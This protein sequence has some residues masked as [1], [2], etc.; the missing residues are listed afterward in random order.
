MVSI[1][2]KGL[3]SG[4]LLLWWP[5]ISVATTPNTVAMSSNSEPVHGAGAQPQTN[6][7][8]SK[9]V[10]YQLMVRLF[11]N[12]NQTNA[13]WGSRQQNGV[14]KLSDINDAALAS[15]KALGVSHIW[16]TGLLHHAT[17]S[18][19]QVYGIS[20]DDPEVVKGRAGSPY[21]I[22]DYYSIHPDL[23]DNPHER[24]AEFQALLARVHQHGLKVIIDLVPNHVARGYQS[25]GKP[26]GVVDFGQQDDT[27]LAYGRDNSFYYVPNVPFQLPQWPAGFHPLGG[28][29]DPRID[30]RFHEFPAKWTG[31][32]ARQPQPAFQDWYETVKV[33]FGV[34]PDGTQDFVRLPEHYRQKDVASHYAFWQQQSVPATWQKFQQIT[35]FWLEQGV[36]GFRYDMAE[37]VPVAFWS[38]LNSH[39]KHLAPQALLLAEIYTPSVY[40]DFLELGKMDYL[41]DKVGLYDTLKG[42]IQGR[43]PVADI[44]SNQQQLHDIRHHMLHFLE[45]HDEQRLASPEFAGDPVRAL[46]ALVLSATLDSAPMMIYFGQEVGEPAAED[47]GFGRAS[48]TTIF[49]Y[50]GVPHHQRWMNQG[51]FDGA[52]LTSSE[53]A[54]RQYYQTLLQFVLSSSALMGEVASLQAA[55]W[56]PTITHPSLASTRSVGPLNH[57]DGY[58]AQLY[59]FARWSPTQ[60]LLISANFSEQQGGNVR[61]KLSGELRQQW[62][63]TVGQY[64]L[65]D[66]LTQ[67]SAI[68]TVTPTEAYVEATIAPLQA[69][70]WQ[71]AAPFSRSNVSALS[72]LPFA[73]KESVSP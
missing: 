24:M 68:L 7:G 51:R 29:F 21:A 32:G 54:L 16:L 37:M 59:S 34:R 62:Q 60:R 64:P 13:P 15:L 63:L 61:L 43:Q 26:E 45:N 39:I 18:N 41:Y 47:A 33:N 71:W 6:Q 55:N 70:I 73:S 2:W 36:D 8:A 50:F 42:V 3:L 27:S 23:A 44:D 31:N 48:R 52:Q 14:G 5:F 30:G 1:Q 17:S 58:H 40:R 10:I 9:V 19:Y 4:V 38:Y 53:Q 12:K 35:Q 65:V 22:K 11:G 49:D 20:N 72:A 46:P 25:I 69:R 28:Q 67:E 57:E 66:A 56:S